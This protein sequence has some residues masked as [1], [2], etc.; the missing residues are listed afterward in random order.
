MKLP[1]IEKSAF[2]HGTYIGYACGVV[3]RIKRVG[4]QW[5]AVAQGYYKGPNIFRKDTL[6]DVSKELTRLTEEY[7]T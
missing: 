5:E 4:D 3:W 1:N 6:T 2:I 7:I